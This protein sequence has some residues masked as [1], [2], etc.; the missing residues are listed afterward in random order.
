ML[1]YESLD[2][3]LNEW[4]EPVLDRHLDDF[5]TDFT[6]EFNVKNPDWR[7]IHDK[8]AETESMFGSFTNKLAEECYDEI[9]QTIKEDDN[10]YIDGWSFA[11]RSAG[12][13]ALLCKGDSEFV[14]EDDL[15]TI[16]EIVEKYFKMFNSGFKQFYK[17]QFNQRKFLSK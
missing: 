3:V 8:A 4:R 1:V 6:I 7:G 5:N 2:S 12:W 15:N 16:E 10:W 11:G 17:D 9:C 13:F 14:S